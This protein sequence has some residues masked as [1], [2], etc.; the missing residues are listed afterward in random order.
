MVRWLSSL[1]LVAL[2][3]VACR[4]PSGTSA[5]AAPQADAAPLAQQQDAAPAVPETKALVKVA[6]ETSGPIAFVSWDGASLVALADADEHSV[7]LLDATTLVTVGTTHL[8]GAPSALTFAG[9]SLF[10]ALADRDQV[11]ELRAHASRKGTLVPVRTQATAREPLALAASE[12][13]LLVLSGKGHALERFTLGALEPSPTRPRVRL[14]REPRSLVLLPSGDVAIGHASE[15][16]LTFVRSND[17]VEGADLTEPSVCTAAMIDECMTLSDLRATQHYGLAAFEDRVLVSGSLSASKG[18]GG[19]ASYGGGG[20]F[21]DAPFPLEGPSGAPRPVVRTTKFPTVSLSV[22]VVTPDTRKV[23]TVAGRRRQGSCALPRAMVVDTPAKEVLVACLGSD[24][25]VRYALTKMRGATVVTDP[26]G[27]TALAGGPVALG[28]LEPTGDV[29]TFAR[30]SRK[31]SLL[32]RKGKDLPV[33]LDRDLPREKPLSAPEAEVAKGRA[34]FYSADKRITTLGLSCGHCHPDGRDDDVVW[35]TPAGPRRP[36]SLVSLPAEGPL[37][38]DAKSPSLEDHVKTTIS[39]HLNGTGLDGPDLA[40]L[41]AYVRSIRPSRTEAGVVAL[42]ESE[43]GRAFAKAGCATCHE[44][45]HGFGDGK[46]HELGTASAFRTPRL[47]GLGGRR[48]LGHDGKYASL[49]A[50]L[51]DTKLKMGDLSPLTPG[52]RDALVA[53]LE[54]LD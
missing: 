4:K 17:V 13:E 10:V 39:K 41:L 19:G 27:E 52:E 49:A 36:L 42:R 28:R 50:M 33:L 23:E 53:F 11:V 16:P 9:G 20:G 14:S 2:L 15:G 45:S 32:R 22:D 29:I 18:A 5:D 44:P 34:L 38:W 26:R 37:A 30:E 25:L 12:T 46:T 43:G 40:A 51:G 47:A 8:S 6:G 54:A 48:A 1:S 7:T 24:K 21:L 31:V 3:L 35:T